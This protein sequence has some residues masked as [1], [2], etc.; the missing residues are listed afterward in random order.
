MMSISTI[1]SSGV[2]STSVIASLPV[3]AVKTCIPLRSGPRRRQVDIVMPEQ[4]GD[5]ALLGGIVLDDQ[6]A[7]AA[8]LHVILDPRQRR[9]EI[10]S[11]ARLVDEGEG[12]AGEP[13]LAVFVERYDLHRD[14]PGGGI[15]LQLAQYGP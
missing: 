7:L 12:A 9:L 11:R 1:A 13:V 4:L 3:V 8:R 2:D 14:M 5:A 15:L 10:L 6:Q